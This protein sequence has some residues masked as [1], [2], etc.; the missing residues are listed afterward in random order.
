MFNLFHKKVTPTNPT[1][2]VQGFMHEKADSL[3]QIFHKSNH[4][5]L[6]KFY[7][8]ALRE[9]S[10]ETI[11]AIVALLDFEMHPTTDKRDFIMKNF[12][13]EKADFSVNISSKVK[14]KIIQNV[15]LE[16]MAKANFR[17]A[18]RGAFV[19][20]ETRPLMLSQMP[21][22][23]DDTGLLGDLILSMS[24]TWVRYSSNYALPDITG[25][26]STLTKYRRLAFD[27]VQA[28]FNVPRCM[29]AL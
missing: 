6:A 27:M 20:K 23:F 1:N 24:D 9:S 15:A 17:R 26:D 5:I 11:P 2:Y 10:A 21:N 7:E 18:R 13:P 12:L 29:L 8:Y 28:G 16:D 22:T 25:M 19:R 4:A 3:V 14:K